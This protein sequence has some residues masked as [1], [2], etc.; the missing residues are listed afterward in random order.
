MMSGLDTD[1]DKSHPVCKNMGKNVK[2]VRDKDGDIWSEG[3][4]KFLKAME[5]D[6]KD[7]LFLVAV[8]KE[9]DKVA[10]L[11]V[12]FQEQGEGWKRVPFSSPQVM[13]G[14]TIK[15]GTIE[16]GELINPQQSNQ[17]AAGKHKKSEASNMQSANDKESPCQH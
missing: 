7:T 14:G 4:F 12:V 6:F 11:Q 15:F 10:I 3:M 5:H 9:D 13:T 2:L 16:F 8:D 1:C 17:F